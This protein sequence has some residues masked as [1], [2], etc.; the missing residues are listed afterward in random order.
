MFKYACWSWATIGAL[1]ALTA[2]GWTQTE[3]PTPTARTTADVI[4]GMQSFSKDLKSYQVPVTLRGGVKVT[5]ITVPF[6][7]QGT[8]YYRAPDEQAIHLNG[9]P[10]IARNFQTTVASMG[11]PQTWPLDYSMSL[12]GTQMNRGHLAYLLVGTPK[13]QGSTVKNVQMWVSVKTFALETVS[14]S[15][16]NGSS[17]NLD[18]SHHG[19]SPYHLPTHITVNAKFRS[20]AGSAQIIYGTYQTNVVIPDS[21]FKKQ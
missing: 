10:T 7:S 6:Q 8:E 14:F 12:Q 21:V 1:T 16:Q 20:Y 9:A 19:Q 15:Y 2:T 5:F 18:F 13:K 4:A 3:Q 17:L 11:S